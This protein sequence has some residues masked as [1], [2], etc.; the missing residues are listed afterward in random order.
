MS[1]KSR[2]LDRSYNLP[3]DTSKGPNTDTPKDALIWGT[4]CLVLGFW[5][6]TIILWPLAIYCFFR[7]IVL[8]KN[9]RS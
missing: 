8:L 4:V 9:R 7:F 1:K 2:W 5:I 3:G 6:F